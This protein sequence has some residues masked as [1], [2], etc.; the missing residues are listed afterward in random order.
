LLP[1]IESIADIGIQAQCSDDATMISG[2][3]LKTIEQH[4]RKGTVSINL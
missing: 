4:P 2:A 3:T 1:V